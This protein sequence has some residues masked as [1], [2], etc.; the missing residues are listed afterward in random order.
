LLFP[1]LYQRCLIKKYDG[2]I[3]I[4]MGGSQKC[5]YTVILGLPASFSAYS[6]DGRGI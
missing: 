5:S 3:F 4:D 6:V 1:Y 2:F